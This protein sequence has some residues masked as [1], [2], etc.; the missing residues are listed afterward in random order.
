[1]SGRTGVLLIHGLGGTEYDLGSLHKAIRRA[2]GDAHIITLPGHGTRPGD[3]VGVR[4]EAWLDAVTAQYRVLE[5][6][7]DTLHVAGMCMGA[8]V[9]L[10]LCHRVRHAKGRLALLAAPVYID[11]WST[12]WYRTLRHLLYR[13]PGLTER[14]R[15]EEG[16]PFGIK[17]PVIRALVKKKFAR[18]DRFHY[19]WVPL[20]TIRQVDRMRAWVRAA[21]PDTPCPTL[22]LHAREDELTSLRSARFLEAAM[23]DARCIV[24]ENSYH[25]ICA[26]NDRDAVARHVLAFFGFDPAH[27]QSPAMARRLARG[28]GSDEAAHALGDAP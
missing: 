19:P 20:A 11:G 13:V 24:L 3:L 16:E 5:A 21:A 22:I 17:N 1:M 9:A 23:P 14:M 7:Y 6:E 28:G 12:P 18:Q 27:A 10:L 26:D 25:M 15:V 2:G 8:L 4:A